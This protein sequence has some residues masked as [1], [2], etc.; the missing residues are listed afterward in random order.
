MNLQELR[1][2]SIAFTRGKIREAIKEDV[3]IIQLV[4][5]IEDL[6]R[7]LNMLIKRL[8][9]WYELT[10]PEVSNLIIKQEDFVDIIRKERKNLMQQFDIKESMGKEFSKKDLESLELLRQECEKIIQ[11][12]EKQTQKLNELMQKHYPNLTT[13]AGGLI[14]GKLIELAGGMKKLIEFPS[15][16]IQI[17]GAEKALFRHIKFGARPPKYGV[18]LGHEYVASSK[19]KAKAAGR[20]A[21]KI[22]IAA[23]VDYFKGEFVGDKLKRMLK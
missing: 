21:D 2:K 4:A 17:L 18:L 8:R 16:T 10:L 11:L 7:I 5:H 6:D 19:Q 9:D 1:K 13:L 3:F 12:R 22:S 23:K 14:G 15:S 20:L